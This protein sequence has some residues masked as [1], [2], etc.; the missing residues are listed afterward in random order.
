MNAENTTALETQEKPADLREGIRPGPVFR[1]DVDIV[2]RSDEF[3]VTA[4]LP[5]VDEAHVR[6]H[7]EDG[8]L[9]I[10]AEPA[11]AADPAW[12]QVYAEYQMGG[13]H[14]EFR[15]TDAVDEERIKATMRD[16]VLQL[17][18]PKTERH[19]PRQITVQ[20]G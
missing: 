17:R 18:L 9:S 16:G 3:Y 8:V 7:L 19:R 20:A 14:R 11:T 5:G 15:L 12:T 1:P 10:D 4:D 6:V 2:E 13:Y